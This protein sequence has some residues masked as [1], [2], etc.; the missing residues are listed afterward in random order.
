M[1]KTEISRYVGGLDDIRGRESYAGVTSGAEAASS[2]IEEG[3]PSVS[4]TPPNPRMA[5]CTAQQSG[6]SPTV[7]TFAPEL[8]ACIP[9]HDAWWDCSVSCRVPAKHVATEMSANPS[10]IAP[11]TIRE[12]R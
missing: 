6:A 7:A 1:R 4:A 10:A 3:G 9:W 12:P 11:E 8:C 2:D 5:C